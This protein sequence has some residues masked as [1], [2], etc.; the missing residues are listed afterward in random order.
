MTVTTMVFDND[1][2]YAKQE[3]RG[4]YDM[5]CV[6]NTPLFRLAAKL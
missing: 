3:K 6:K 2:H 1:N 5:E 4:I